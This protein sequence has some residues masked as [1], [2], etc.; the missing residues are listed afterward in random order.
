VNHKIAKLGALAALTCFWSV[1]GPARISSAASRPIDYATGCPKDGKY[2]AVFAVL[3]DTTDSL[4]PVQQEI[5]QKKLDE[6]GGKVP[7]YGKLEVFEV[8][9]SSDRLIEPLLEVCNPGRADDTNEWTGNPRLMEKRWL[10]KFKNPLDKSLKAALS[11]T[12]SAK[13]SPIMEEI[14]QVSVQAFFETPAKTSRRLAIVSDMLQNSAILNQY[15]HLESFEEFEHQPGFV[16]VRPELN[17]VVLTI[18]YV[19]RSS[20]FNRQ[21]KRHVEFW[22]AFFGASGARIEEVMSV[23]GQVHGN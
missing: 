21:G 16:K 17:D 23:S 3:L 6:F 18:L 1:A 14:Q 19:R 12:V 10:D 4:S 9:P 5:A 22:Q 13:Q 11:D 15:R 8:R 7:R 2:S 20:E